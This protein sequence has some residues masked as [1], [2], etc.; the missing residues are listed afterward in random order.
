MT[1]ASSCFDPWLGCSVALDALAVVH[2]G[3]AGLAA[4][5]ERRL[6][7]LLQAATRGSR[8]WHE[9]LRGAGPGLERIAPAAKR[10]LMHDFDRWVTDPR[11]RLAPLRAFFADPSRVGEA[12]GEAFIAWES[13]PA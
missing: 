2:G 11:L 4:R 5:R 10:E 8:F 3:A 13:S 9:R 6:A 1:S 7:A 12:F